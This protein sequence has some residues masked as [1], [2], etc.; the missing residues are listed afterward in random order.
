MK[1]RL[2]KLLAIC[3]SISARTV[4]RRHINFRKIGQLAAPVR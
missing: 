2:G 3:V 1:S 4:R